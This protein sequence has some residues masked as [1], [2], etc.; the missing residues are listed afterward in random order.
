MNEKK[1]NLQKISALEF[2][3]RVKEDCYV[4][5]KNY[6]LFLGAGCS[7]SSGIPD[8]ASLVKEWLEKLYD[9]SNE[10]KISYMKWIKQEFPEFREENAA[11]YYGPLMKRRFHSQGDRQ[12]EIERICSNKY[13]GFGYAVLSN[14]ILNKSEKFNIAL[15]TNFDDLIADSLYIYQGVR[16]LVISHESLASYIRPTRTRPLIVK[17]HG[18]YHLSPL[19]IPEEIKNIKTEYINQTRTL[20]ADRGLII[21]GYGGND[22]GIKDMLENLPSNALPFPIYWISQNEP[23]CMLNEFLYQKKAIWVEN[24]DFDELMLLMKDSFDINHPEKKIWE[25]IF[26]NYLSVY[27]DLRT[28]ILSANEDNKEED[29]ALKN[30]LMKADENLPG[31]YTYY[32]NASQFEK[33][34]AKKAESIYLDG[35]RNYPNSQDLIGKYAVFAH[36]IQR[37]LPKA[38][39]LYLKALS[40]DPDNEVNNANYGWFL[41]FYC[42]DYDNAEKYYEKTLQINNKNAICLCNYASLHEKK[43]K[44]YNMA[45][46]YYKKAIEI[47]PKNSYLLITY[48]RFLRSQRKD[49]NKSEYFYEEAIKYNESD[50]DVFGY[51]AIFLHVIRKDYEKANNYYKKSLLINPNNPNNN[52]NYTGFLFSNRKNKE[53]EKQLQYTLNLEGKEYYLGMELELWFYAFL[54]SDKIAKDKSLKILKELLTRGERSSYEALILNVEVAIEDGHIEKEWLPVLHEVIID[55]KEINSLKKWG[56]WEKV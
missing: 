40:L 23:N 39:S 50:E 18:D 51:Y 41:H 20:I 30:A 46:N 44:D 26:E 15:T 24:R 34:N 7:V 52:C 31:W 2:V 35:L 22:S 3:N 4:P 11:T 27:K 1:T 16:P 55:L 6:A 19:N 33:V 48:A 53:A 45:E 21:I 54:H 17:L 32:M 5:D 28:K 38:K 36:R 14:L 29:N 9:L 47:S 49:Y 56:M 25:D 42:K 12:A 37:N 13:P 43:Y 8:A 10:N